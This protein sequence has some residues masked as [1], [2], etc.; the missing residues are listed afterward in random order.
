MPSSVKAALQDTASRREKTVQGL[1]TVL[2]LHNG[3]LSK[4]ETADGRMAATQGSQAIYT[5][6]ISDRPNWS[7]FQLSVPYIGA[8]D[9][10]HREP[11]PDIDYR[12][13]KCW[14]QQLERV[15]VANP[16]AT[17]IAFCVDVSLQLIEV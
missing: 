6:T 7:K 12:V 8:L 16:L 9:L 11:C 10:G 5:T 2:P 14:D 13:L 15:Q 4:R 3:L 1:A 17:L